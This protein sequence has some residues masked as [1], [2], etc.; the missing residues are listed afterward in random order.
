MGARRMSLLK[1]AAVTLDL[2]RAIA[3][4]CLLININNTDKNKSH[5]DVIAGRDGILISIRRFDLES[6][7]NDV[8]RSCKTPI[9]F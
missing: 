2:G 9:S 3:R 6:G 7:D 8:D 5:F 1:G 4:G